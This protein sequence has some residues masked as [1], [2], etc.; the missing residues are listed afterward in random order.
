MT[1]RV[2]LI[3][4]GSLASTPRM[5]KAADALHEAGYRVRVVCSEHVDWAVEAG[6]RLRASRPWPCQVV[7]WHPRTG[8][9]VYLRSAV[10]HRLARAAAGVGPR[11]VPLA[12]LART[13]SRVAPELYRAAVAAPADLVYAGT[14]GALAVAAAAA[15]RL[16]APYA[17]DLED[18]HSAEQA[19]G[20]PGLG[21]AVME[22]I[23]RRVLPGAAF[24]TA[25]SRPI[26]DAY[27]AKYGVRP[28]VVNNVFPLPR[29]G[30][31]FTRPADAPLRLHWFS[32]QVGPGRGL[33]DVVRA[34]GGLGRPLA[35]S[36]LGHRDEGYVHSLRALAA[37]V[38]PGLRIEFLPNR[39][40]D[41][42]LDACRGA[43]VGL[44]LE[45]GR[46]LSRQLCLTNKVFTY[47]LAGL[48]V[49]VTD[50]E[51]QRPVAEDLGEGA[52]LYKPGDAAALAAGLRRWAD[53]GA[54]L[55]RA[56]R[57]CWEAACRRWHWEHP[58]ERG[59]LLGAV[60]GVF[61]G[62]RACAV[63]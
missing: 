26:A 50:T 24:L 39:P 10:R 25:G 58:L 19:G 34:V 12:V 59:A 5:L 46:P 23:E 4:A 7:D 52:I 22:Q 13:A 49:A 38:A 40:P 1:P 15:R 45:T 56:K 53:D 29:Q 33:E 61:T 21:D 6:L 2:C 35:L 11:R 41:E 44:A 63:C 36:V 31:D 60:A 14:A 18:F 20:G 32:Q 62:G 28:V 55:V 30:P 43:D 48:A 54:A 51:G 9:W 47:V 57:A 8:R 27:A 37:S 16:A 42:M 3:T 17:L